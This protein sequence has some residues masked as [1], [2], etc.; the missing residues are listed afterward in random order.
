[1]K[2]LVIELEDD[3]HKKIKFKAFQQEVTMKDYVT[4]LVKKDLEVKKEQTQ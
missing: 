2:R 3:L 4:E 1:M